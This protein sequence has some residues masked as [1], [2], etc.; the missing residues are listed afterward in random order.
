MLTI[1][2]TKE[3]MNTAWYLFELTDKMRMY[4]SD[5][6]IGSHDPTTGE[7]IRLIFGSDNDEIK[8]QILRRNGYIVEATYKR[9]GEI[10]E[11]QP[12]GKWR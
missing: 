5:P 2:I 1:S 11:F 9:T 7:D 4:V 12:V 3:H 6:V 10:T 8:M